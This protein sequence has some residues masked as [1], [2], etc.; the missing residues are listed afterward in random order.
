[1]GGKRIPVDVEKFGDLAVYYQREHLCQRAA[2]P[3]NGHAQPT[4]RLLDLAVRLDQTGGEMEVEM[5]CKDCSAVWIERYG[6]QLTER[7]AS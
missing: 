2:G 3:T 1:M 7:V 4:F 5:R 6:L